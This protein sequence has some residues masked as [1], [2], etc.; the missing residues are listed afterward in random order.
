MEKILIVG[1]AGYVGTKLTNNLLENG[2]KVRVLDTFWFGNH[3]ISHP[4]LEIMV[5]DVRDEKIIK[6]SLNSIDKVIHLAC[7]SNDPSYD[8]DPHLGKSINF[9][10]FPMF[11]KQV[12]ESKVQRFVYASSSSVYGVKKEKNVTED[13]R[14]E[15]LTDYS[16]FKAECEKIILNTKSSLEKVILRPATICGY[17]PRQ[18]LDLAVN[19]LTNHGFHNKKIIVNGGDQLR[20]NL[21]IDDMVDAYKIVLS[22]QK[23]FIDNQ[24]F[25]VGSDNLTINQIAKLVQ[26]NLDFESEIIYKETNDAR[27]Y[28]VS[29]KKFS[30]IFNWMPKRN[31]ENAIEDLIEAFKLK[32]IENTFENSEYFNIKKLKEVINERKKS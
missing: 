9:D 15:P 6:K 2:Y 7:I 28:H 32:K 10:C 29:S 13:L 26:A 27:S 1:G 5:G 4:N 20:P 17:S 14:L 31:V 3:L 16:R 24:I 23:E 8:L 18:R 12:C 22:A 11:I 30:E 25:N 19:I 21:H